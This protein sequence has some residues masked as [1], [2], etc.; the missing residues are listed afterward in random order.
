MGKP[1][2]EVIVVRCRNSALGFAWK[3]KYRC[4]LPPASTSTGIQSMPSPAAF[5]PSSN[6]ISGSEQMRHPKLFAW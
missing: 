3:R 4:R 2:G 1:E 6:R 5:S